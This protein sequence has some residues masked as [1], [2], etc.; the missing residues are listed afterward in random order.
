MEGEYPCANCKLRAR[1]DKNPK[2]LLGRFWRWHINF[3][4]GFRGYFTS[5][6]EQT[7]AQIREKYNFE[8]YK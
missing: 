2:S 3:C 7:K 8:K 1:Y 4:P 5:R 6:D